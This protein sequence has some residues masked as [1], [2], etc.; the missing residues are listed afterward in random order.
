MYY[1]M[2]SDA[3]KKLYVEGSLKNEEDGFAFELKNKI[4]SGS[5]SGIA[6]ISV[7]GEE[8]SLDGVTIKLGDKVREASSLS[9]S[10]SLFV[11]YGKT[12]KIHVPGELEPGKHEIKLKVKAQE[13]GSLTLPIEDTVG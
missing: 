9:W 4:D 12:L 1:V 2:S 13:I 10:N 11:T 5:V 6:A 7:D 3:L 8:R